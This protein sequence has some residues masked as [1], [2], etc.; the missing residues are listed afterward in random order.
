MTTYDLD[1][2]LDLVPTATTRPTTSRRFP[3]LAY[4]Y[5]LRI[6]LWAV[7]VGAA[8]VFPL[9]DPYVTRA[10]L[11]IHVMSMAVGFGSVVMVDVYGLLWLFGRKTLA[12]VVELA[13]V[14]HTVIAG[15]VGGLMA[16]GIALRPDLSSPLARLKMILVLVLMLNGAAAQRMLHRMR[17][18]LPPETRGANIPWAGF[19]RVMT[20]AMISQ[21]TWWGAI[22]IGFITN[23][24]RH[25]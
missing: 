1:M 15:A 12:D 16:S 21:S 2:T 22:A 10:A 18:T 19:Q 7:V 13:T 4:D 11:F 6:G 24:N 25:S 9:D 5:A 17:R 14:A 3:G 23:A 20:A 8:S